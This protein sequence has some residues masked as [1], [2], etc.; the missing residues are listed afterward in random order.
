MNKIQKI[1]KYLLW[2]INILLIAIPAF[3]AIMWYNI[4]K[5]SLNN[6]S[7]L[8]LE[9]S[10][11]LREDAFVDWSFNAKFVGGFGHVVNFI[12]FYLALL[13]LK[14]IFKNYRAGIVFSTD[15]AYLYKCLGLLIL[16]DSIVTNPIGNAIMAHSVSLTNFSKAN[17]FEVSYD[18]P[19]IEGLISGVLF[20]VVS[21]VMYE[22]SLLEEES[23]YT[24]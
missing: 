10:F 13:V 15:N 19:S 21:M 4:D 9:N 23:Q 18:F 1:S 12:A 22:A 24:V 8:M 7:S 5:I 20:I 14:L 11:Q 3:I 2:A 16:I 6:F 17:L